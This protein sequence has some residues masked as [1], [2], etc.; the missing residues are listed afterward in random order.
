[1]CV[2]HST[3]PLLVSTEK[4]NFMDIYD[5]MHGQRQRQSGT[6][7]SKWHRWAQIGTDGTDE[8]NLAQ[9]PV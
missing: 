4:I 2:P 3:L 5:V 8:F 7:R 6:G 9:V 1:M